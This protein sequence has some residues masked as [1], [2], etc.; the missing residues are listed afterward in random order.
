MDFTGKDK[1]AH[2]QQRLTETIAWCASQDWST[3]PAER[4][5][6][7]LLRPSEQAT[8]QLTFPLDHH[9]WDKNLQQRQQIVEDL[10]LKRAA[11]LRTRG[12]SRSQM[13]KPLTGGRLL[14]FSPDMTLFDG[15]SAAATDSFFDDDDFP[16]WDTWITYV[17]DDP[18]LGPPT[19]TIFDDCYLLSWVPEP[20]VE[21]IDAG[22]SVNCTKC[23]FWAANLD[24]ML[25]RQ[26]KHAGL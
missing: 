25:M 15:A 14:V 11:L 4:L 23:F 20:L 12:I 13:T 6:T 18:P 7:S 17:A 22:I 19:D 16:A 8:F 9:L 3:N 2:I 21:V 10:A 5:R 26:L 24:T 1:T